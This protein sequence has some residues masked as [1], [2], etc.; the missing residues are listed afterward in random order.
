MT[1]NNE[2]KGPIPTEVGLLTDLTTFD[3]SKHYI[4]IW[5]LCFETNNI[6]FT[7][8]TVSLSSSSAMKLQ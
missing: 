3:L 1:G 5:L 8:L 7:V 6:R 2:L 4:P